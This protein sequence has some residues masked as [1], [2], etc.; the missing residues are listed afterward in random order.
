VATDAGCV[1]LSAL[2]PTEL[3][4]NTVT[5]VKI[6]KN[7]AVMLIDLFRDGIFQLPDCLASGTEINRS[8]SG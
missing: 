6:P 2:S 4:A 8:V 5:T 7:A 1:A 3:I